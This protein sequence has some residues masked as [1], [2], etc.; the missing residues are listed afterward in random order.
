MVTLKESKYVN[1]NEFEG[2][3]SKPKFQMNVK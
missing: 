1:K 3:R 2:Q